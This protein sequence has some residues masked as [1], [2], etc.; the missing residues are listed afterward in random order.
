MVRE[1]L[2]AGSRQLSV[3]VNPVGLT[4][5]GQSGGQGQN[6]H[7]AE[8]R[9]AAGATTASWAM[10]SANL[11]APTFPSAW[12]RLKR[13]ANTFTAYRGATARTGL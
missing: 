4:R 7:Y 3:G 13:Q 9:R 12:L 1:D 2:T 11:D 5:D 10:P 6:V 8:L